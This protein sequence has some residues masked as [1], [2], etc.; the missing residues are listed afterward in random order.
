MEL[1]I[2]I[3]IEELSEGVYLA[4]SNELRAWSQRETQSP[5]PSKSPAM[6]REN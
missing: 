5:K 4:T 2:A 1:A 6:S 3:Q